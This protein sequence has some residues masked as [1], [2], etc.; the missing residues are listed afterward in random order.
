[1]LLGRWGQQP[2]KDMT[3]LGIDFE[4]HTYWQGYTEEHPRPVNVVT[5]LF[6]DGQLDAGHCKVKPSAAKEFVS[7][8]T[9]TITS[10]KAQGTYWNRI[11]CEEQFENP[12]E[13]IVRQA[14]INIDSQVW[15]SL[16]DSL[17]EIYCVDLT[18][19]YV[20]QESTSSRLMC[21]KERYDTQLPNKPLH[22]KPSTKR[23]NGKQTWY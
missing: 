21:K 23:G 15:K 13:A 16:E 20:M 8:K 5:H 10:G 12:P 18:E 11:K 7:R 4:M 17:P 3:T 19:A 2:I 1:M 22:Q 9:R 6:G 14:T